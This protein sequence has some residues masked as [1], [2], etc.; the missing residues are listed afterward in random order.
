MTK[1]NVPRLRFSGFSNNFKFL[2]IGDILKIKNGKSQKN[3]EVSEG[4]YPILGTGGII[5]RTNSFL[6]DKESVLIGRKGTI[7]KPM[8]MDTPFWT[9]DTLFY[10]EIKS[11]SDAKF[12]YFLFNTIEWLKY[13][14]STGVPSLTSTNIESI[15]V[16]IPEKIEQQ[17]IGDFFAK[18][19]KLIELQTQKVDQLKKLKRGYLQKMFPQEGETVPRLRFSRFSGKWK[20]EKLDSLLLECN[21][22]K[23]KNVEN[24][25]L[26]KVRLHFKGVKTTTDHPR[27]TSKGRKYFLRKPGDLII[28]KQNFH[29]G[30]FAIIPDNVE[31][32]V[33]SS[34]IV[35]FTNKS[36]CNL[37][38]VNFYMMNN[39][40]LRRTTIF[41]GGTGQKEYSVKTLKSL[42]IKIPTLEE[43]EK[44]SK[45]FKVIDNK[46]AYEK[47]K[48]NT[49]NKLKKAYLQ[50]MFI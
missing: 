23:V 21:N 49:L 38:F 46:I 17:K 35:S 50:K 43:Q 41:I 15:F 13:N 7:N 20:E 8:Y 4:K 16:S 28:G 12:V 2:H 6:C 10:S 42:K 11:N 34:A 39:D 9:V 3:V 45:F 25:K 18:Q 19:D 1:T 33:A 26:L 29:N 27:V 32:Y 48:L 47:D 44:I 5:G 24:Y 31:G 37:N 22:R 14:T 36:N 40:W 30:G